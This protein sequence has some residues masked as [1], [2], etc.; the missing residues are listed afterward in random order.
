MDIVNFTI[1]AFLVIAVIMLI[2]K[3]NN[4]NT[5]NEKITNSLI[6][7]KSQPIKRRKYKRKYIPFTYDDMLN[8]NLSNN[9]CSTLDDDPEKHY[10]ETKLLGSV[11]CDT[12][13]QNIQSEDEFNDNFF[14]FRDQTNLSSNLM[15]PNATEKIAQLYLEDNKSIARNYTGMKIGDLYDKLTY[16]PRR[17]CVRVPHHNQE[18]DN[19]NHDGY[20]AHIGSTPMSLTRVLNTYPNEKVMNGGLFHSNV[21]GDEKCVSSYKP[22][23]EIY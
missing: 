20:V 13:D 17:H 16:V 21:T 7:T 15:F 2:N 19:L 11:P 22:L 8:I 9:Y 4:P 1:I 14:S 5:N 23:S 10:I 6:N 12:P 3:N 18:F